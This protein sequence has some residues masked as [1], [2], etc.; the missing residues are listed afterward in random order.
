MINFNAN[1]NTARVPLLIK[2]LAYNS[3]SENPGT[4]SRTVQLVMTDGDGG[5]SVP[6]TKSIAVTR[7]ND[8]PVIGPLGPVVTYS[9]GDAP[10]S[11]VSTSAITDI[12][13][14]NF[15]TGKLTVAITANAQTTD[16]LAIKSSGTA[17]GQLSTTADFKVLLGGVQIG[18]YTGGVGTVP[19]VVTFNAT[20]TPAVAQQVLAS[21]QYSNTSALPSLAQRTIR[22]TQ[23]DGDGGTSS[24]VL[25][26]ISVNDDPVIGTFGGTLTYTRGSAAKLITTTAT[27]TDSS[28][29][30]N[31]GV[32][33]LALSG[34]DGT[35]VLAIQTSAALTIA[36]TNEIFLNGFKLGTFVGG[37]NNT[38]LVITLTANAT[39]AKVLTLLKAIQFSSTTTATTPTPRTLQVT[40]TDGS[41]GV[42]SV[43]SKAI[44]IQ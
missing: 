18:S 11:F 12:D 33:T 5:T 29:N 36:N 8:V 14:I 41:G 10:I 42:S 2:A 39:S 24:A 22:V 6:A 28:T 17:T 40:L 43:V 15:D 23:T 38:N 35:D 30:F 4:A 44:N 13:S 19:L 7:V 16:R 34:S 26:K 3:T 32:L 37:K 9:A 21:I 20:V 25:Q 31:T 1:A 27:I